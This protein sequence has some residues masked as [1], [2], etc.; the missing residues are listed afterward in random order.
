M[1]KQPTVPEERPWHDKIEFQV[2]RS[3]FKGY[4]AVP[5]GGD[6]PGVL[7]IHAWWGLNTFFR[8]VSDRL[9][10]EG[11]VALAP[12]L[13]NGKT[14]STID[15]AKR[16]RSKAKSLVVQKELNGAI[17]LLSSLFA[18][19]GERIGVLG[20]SLGAYWGMGLPHRDPVKLPLLQPSMG[21]EA[22]ITGNLVQLS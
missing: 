19:S 2:G 15:E 3:E 20:F 1:P 8:G 21:R 7:V 13:Y 10:S 12:D 22:G 4:L 9:A 6:V 17:D 18:V 14:A 5:E 11:F 16:L